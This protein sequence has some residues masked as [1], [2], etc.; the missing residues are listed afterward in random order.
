MK[1]LAPTLL[2]YKLE[3]ESKLRTKNWTRNSFSYCYIYGD[4]FDYN[5]NSNSEDINRISWVFFKKTE[6]HFIQL[7]IINIFPVINEWCYVAK[8][9][10]EL[11]VKCYDLLRFYQL[12]EVV[13]V[14]F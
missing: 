6:I 13:V 9:S 10:D 3:A 14:I 7:N 2:G 4:N 8:V 5:L 11:D 12:K 1:P